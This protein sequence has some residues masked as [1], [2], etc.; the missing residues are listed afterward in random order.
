M[1][2]HKRKH[3]PFRR[4]LRRIFNRSYSHRWRSWQH[5]TRAARQLMW[6]QEFLE[7]WMPFPEE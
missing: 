4:H 1:N 7:Q 6:R 2:R 5:L 3:L